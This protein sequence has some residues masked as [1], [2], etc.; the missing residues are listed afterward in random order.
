MGAKY[1]W[2]RLRRRG[3]SLLCV[4]GSVFC[5]VILVF[6]YGMN[7]DREYIHPIL[8]QLLPAGHCACQTS[9]TFQ[10]STCV[11]CADSSSLQQS[12]SPGWGFQYARDARNEALDQMQCQAAFQ[13][14]FEDVTRGE[15]FWRAH[16]GGLVTEDLDAITIQPGMARAFISQG[17]LHVV[18]ARAKGED[19][20][21]KILGVLSSIHRALAADRDRASRRDI[22]FVFSVEDKVED[23][24]NPE[25][26][27]W[28]F[29]RT[30]MEEGVW[31][32]PDFSFWAWD[33]PQ[34]L[35][36]FAPK[37]RRALIEAARDKPWGDVKQVNWDT[38]SNVLR[39]EDHCQ[40]MFI[41]HVEGEFFP[42]PWRQLSPGH[43]V[44]GLLTRDPF[45]P[46][47]RS[48]SASLKYRQA[49]HSV[50]VAHKLQYIQHHHYLLVAHGPNQ[51]YVEVERDFSDL[52]EKIEPLVADTDAA[53]RIAT[54]SVKTFRERYLTPAA[55][56]CYWRAL[57]DGY[58][59]VWNSSVNHWSDRTGKERGL[60][61]ESFVML[62]SE[63]MLEFTADA[64]ISGW[65]S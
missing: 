6:W 62:E 9:T 34:K 20:R 36:C 23:V 48:Y 11:S 31:L 42:R 25:Y 4:I 1:P 45:A 5:F 55:E 59:N 12:T 41:A 28:V 65:F 27:V 53:H 17:Y 21:R 8:T 49:C 51:N 32:M 43:M 13:G 63:K 58:G 61:Y 37:L 22:E 16:G 15:R 44:H 47:G 7:S 24:T 46:I 33:N 10:C 50:I 2:M 14:L 19:H 64:A 18:T 40:Y 29:A 57:F 30:P 56:A 26:P 38:G 35:Y 3:L 52:A 60:R 54:N 39:M